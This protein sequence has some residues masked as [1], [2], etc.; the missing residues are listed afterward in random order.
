MILSQPSASPQHSAAFDLRDRGILLAD[1][2]FDTSLVRGGQVVLRAAHLDRLVEGATA[3]GIALE[4]DAVADVMDAA[5]EGVALGALRITVTRGAGAR[6][7][8]GEAVAAPTLIANVSDYDASSPPSPVRAQESAILRN[9]TSFTAR[10]KTLSY[11]DNIAALRAA[12]AA[13]FEEAFFFTAAGNLA[14]ASVANVFVQ[15]GE[16]IFTPP[17]SDGALPG[18]MRNWLLEQG[19]IGERTVSERSISREEL[20]AADRVFLTNS[21]RLFQPVS[22]LGDKSFEA[23]LPEGCAGLRS[24]LI[25]S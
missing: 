9:P 10:Y 16:A 23:G 20:N 19:R 22:A 12:M 15:S 4:R 17:V 3:L 24:Q 18:V 21:L 6:G 14:C 11:T 8:A 2:V 5:I 7:L 13:G 1:G 25:G